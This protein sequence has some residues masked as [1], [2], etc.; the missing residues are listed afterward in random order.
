MLN[1]F[2]DLCVTSQ[3]RY[4]RKEYTA[5][6]AGHVSRA[7]LPS[8]MA[9]V[10]VLADDDGRSVDD[11][12][13][14]LAVAEEDEEEEADDG[15]ST[16]ARA[17]SPASAIT[18][19]GGAPRAGAR[20]HRLDLSSLR[21]PARDRKGR[22]KGE[23]G[24]PPPPPTARHWYE[25]MQQRMV[26]E[27]TSGGT[28]PPPAL[29]QLC[30]SSDV[31]PLSW[32]ELKEAA[33]AQRR[34]GEKAR[35]VVDFLQPQGVGYDPATEAFT[36]GPDG[37]P[38]LA[39][40]SSSEVD[41]WMDW[42]GRWAVHAMDAATAAEAAATARYRRAMAAAKASASAAK[43]PAG[44]KEGCTSG[45]MVVAPVG[46]CLAAN[47]AA[48]LES[49]PP[50]LPRVV[51]ELP[52]VS[53]SRDEFR[54]ALGPST[55]LADGGARVKYKKWSPIFQPLVKH[56]P[57]VAQSAATILCVEAYG[58]LVHEGTQFPVTLVSCGAPIITYPVSILNICYRF[59]CAPSLVAAT[60]CACTPRSWA[61][62]SWGTLRTAFLW[63]TPQQVSV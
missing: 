6:V 41:S 50:A 57:L 59:G 15:P 14:S 18:P 25:R 37:V 9:G 44:F 43:E 21:E 1:V 5:V 4:T 35:A 55:R 22:R 29:L 30:G 10:T 40:P 49:V 28:P 26:R 46:L 24:L 56:W 52:V 7:T 12:A 3:A 8:D 42:V 13:A 27:H 45:T 34:P 23:A 61:T 47:G 58:W 51:I 54:M 2:E 38:V 60:S 39:I 36:L 31:K 33:K 62:P 19:S 48:V 53:I 32:Y 16:G 17:D 11:V 63:P 20:N